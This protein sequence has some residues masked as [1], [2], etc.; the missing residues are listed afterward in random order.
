MDLFS[1]NTFGLFLFLLAVVGVSIGVGATI[2]RKLRDRPTAQR[3]P[4]GVVQGALLG[5]VGLMLAFGLSMAVSRYDGRRQLVVAEANDIG[6]TYLR[7][8]LLDEPQRATSLALLSD[9]TDAAIQLAESVPGSDRFRAAR[10]S[11]ENLQ[12]ELWTAAGDAVH[13]DPDGSVPRLY[14]ET[15]N[16]MID[17]H[18]ERVASV[19]NRVPPSVMWL[20]VLGSALS[21]GFLAYYVALLGSRFGGSV[22]AMMAV[23]LILFVSFD[24]DRPQRGFIKVP[25]TALHDLRDSMD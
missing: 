14:I 11:M 16:S 13:A 2:G 6:T 8:Q 22:V 24:L 21:V 7:A 10:A 19:N 23:V 4:V 25:S 15:L 12:T 18:T 9:Y 20:L 3:E 17:V 1:L 5:L